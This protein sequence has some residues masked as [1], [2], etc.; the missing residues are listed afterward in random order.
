MFNFSETAKI[1]YHYEP[2]TTAGAIFRETDRINLYSQYKKLQ[3]MNFYVIMYIFFNGIYPFK[4][5]L[6]DISQIIQERE[7][8]IWN[9]SCMKK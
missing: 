8:G 5:F 6:N 9:N 4:H 1:S 3:K 2:F 7:D